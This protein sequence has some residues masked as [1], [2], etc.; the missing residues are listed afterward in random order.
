MMIQY[1]CVSLKQ[2]PY[3]GLSPLKTVKMLEGRY[4]RY[5][6]FEENNASAFQTDSMNQNSFSCVIIAVS[7]KKIQVTNFKN[8]SCIS[9]K[10]ISG[11]IKNHYFVSRK[12]MKIIPLIIYN[13]WESQQEQYSLQRSGNLKIETM[14]NDGGYAFLVLAGG[15]YWRVADD[16]N[17]QT[18]YSETL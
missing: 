10:I 6:R 4:T 15:H 3:E 13:T 14:L 17:K 16:Y 9:E 1:G 11:R 12:K 8:D 7:E 5:K 2:S 18:S